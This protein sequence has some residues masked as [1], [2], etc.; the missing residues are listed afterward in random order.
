MDYNNLNV[1]NLDNYED[2][3][4]EPAAKPRERNVQVQPGYVDQRHCQMEEFPENYEKVKDD[5]L[6]RTLIFKN[7]AI[8]L[9]SLLRDS[10]FHVQIRFLIA[11]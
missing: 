3:E 10:L 7:C 8:R 2:A 9:V 1:S 11:E 5:W 6:E 4:P